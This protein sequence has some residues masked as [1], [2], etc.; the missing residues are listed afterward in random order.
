MAARHLHH[1]GYQSV[2]I[3]VP[4]ATDKP[5]FVGLR[6]QCASLGLPFLEPDAVLT[7]PALRQRYDLVVDALFGFSFKGPVRPP[8]D[9]LLRQLSAAPGDGGPAVASV[10]VPSGWDVDADDLPA[11]GL[12]P[13][14]LVSLT[15]PKLCAR[16]FRGRHWL[17]GRF[18]PPAIRE[19]F[20]LHGLPPFPGGS[21]TVELVTAAAVPSNDGDQKN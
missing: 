1:F 3:C 17:G 11:G 8:F 19:R 10:D 16:A 4:K 14:L 7:P 12:R 6:R 13:D 5:L 15:A 2:A 18:V 21:Q 9:A 20:A